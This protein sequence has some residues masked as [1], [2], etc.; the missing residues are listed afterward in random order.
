MRAFMIVFLFA[1]LG[2]SLPTSAASPSGFGEELQQRSG[3]GGGTGARG[4]RCASFAKANR[5]K[6][7]WDQRV[8]SCVCV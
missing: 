5:C 3:G 8:R 7:R 4:G 6:P 1:V 2:I